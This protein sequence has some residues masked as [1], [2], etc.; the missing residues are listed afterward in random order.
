SDLMIANG[1]ILNVPDGL[2]L[3]HE[4]V[5]I[6][7]DV[8][9][10]VSMF[11]VGDKTMIACAPSC[12]KC[13]PCKRGLYSTCDQGGWILG[14]LIDG[15]LAEYARI[16]DADINLHHIPEGVDEGTLI[17]LKDILPT[18]FEYSVP[19]GQIKPGDTVV[20]FGSGHIGLTALLMAQIHS[21]A[22]I[23]MVDTNLHCLEVAEALGAT[24]FIHTTD[25]NALHDVL[26]H[27]GGKSVDVAIIANAK[28]AL[29]SL[30]RSFGQPT[31]PLQRV[32]LMP[33]RR[34][35]C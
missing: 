16:P 4:G 20:I 3:G 6:I 27:S 31:L 10:A 24:K 7:E 26:K 34:L 18:G 33:S 32:L 11:E 17:M 9:S 12:G 25:G 15:T 29:N 28:V 23:I 2:T 19:D 5:G 35:C 8:G 13:E 22:E 14:R 30:W 21:P 1:E